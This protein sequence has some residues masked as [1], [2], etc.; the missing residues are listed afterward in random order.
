MNSW[1]S[2]VLNV[3]V[4][5]C[6][7]H[8]SEG[9][10]VGAGINLCHKHWLIWRQYSA[11]FSRVFNL[12][13]FANFQPLVNSISIKFLTCEV[14]MLWL[15]E[16]QWTTSWGRAAEWQKGCSPKRYLQT[17]HWFADRCKLEQTTVW[18]YVI[19]RTRIACHVAS[20]PGPVWEWGYMPR[21]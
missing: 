17:R 8:K 19:D 21:P 15:Q 11:N 16:G 18:Q 5:V 1:A 20:F 14:F 2:S 13:N 4:H 6:V 10:W 7:R 3:Y 12:A 9:G